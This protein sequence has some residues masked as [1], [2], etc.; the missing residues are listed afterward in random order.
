M[1]AIGGSPQECTVNGRIFSLAAD[2]GAPRKIGGSEN[3][4]QPNGNGTARLVKKR[5]AWKVTLKLSIDDDNGDLEFLQNLADSNSFFVFSYT[6]ASGKT[7]GN[8]AAQISGEVVRE[9]E[10]ATAEV[11]FEGGGKLET[12]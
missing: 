8:G 10:S 11:T 1:A 4:V 12:L 2:S 5:V 7:Y 3:E 9:G 6:E